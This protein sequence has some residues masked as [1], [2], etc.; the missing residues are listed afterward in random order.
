MRQV[1]VIRDMPEQ[2][3]RT[4]WTFL[5]L[6]TLGQHAN[7]AESAHASAR[8][9]ITTGAKKRKYGI[10]AGV[11]QALC[12]MISYRLPA[13]R[14]RLRANDPYKSVGGVEQCDHA[15]IFVDQS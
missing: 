2:R 12:A 10:R 8:S 13:F 11:P 5:S 14:G 4:A 1:P 6:L 9:D 7:R 15:V 3:R